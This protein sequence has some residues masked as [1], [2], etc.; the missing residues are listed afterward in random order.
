MLYDRSDTPSPPS[1]PFSPPLPYSA[2]SIAWQRL[3][4]TIKWF[5]GTEEKKK[6]KQKKREKRNLQADRMR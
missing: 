6:H 2:L 3:K 1:L 4:R 5:F